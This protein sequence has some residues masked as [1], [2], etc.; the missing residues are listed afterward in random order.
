MIIIIIIID[1]PVL[2]DLSKD[3]RALFGNIPLQTE[4]FSQRK[5]M[6]GWSATR[7][8]V[9]FYNAAYVLTCTV[10]LMHALVP[11]WTLRAFGR[12]IRIMLFLS[13][14]SSV[15]ANFSLYELS[16]IGSTSPAMSE[17]ARSFFSPMTISSSTLSEP[18]FAH[19]M[20]V[21]A[22]I[23]TALIWGVNLQSQHV[24]TRQNISHYQKISMYLIASNRPVGELSFGII[25]RSL[26]LQN[27]SQELQ[28]GILGT[29]VKERFVTG[30]SE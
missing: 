11:G 13:L 10:T 2:R 12:F 29:F 30:S 18:P 24:F 4:R 28:T 8:V 14:F 22:R 21:K 3:T 27:L 26:Q 6:L 23:L 1:G 17:L 5:L 25:G 20:M 16:R 9:E 7:K 15:K 19:P